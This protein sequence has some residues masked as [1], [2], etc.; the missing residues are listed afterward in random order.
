MKKVRLTPSLSL[1]WAVLSC[2]FLAPLAASSA[3]ISEDNFDYSAGNTN[4]LDGGTGWAGSWNNFY[5][6]E[7]SAIV[8]PTTALTYSNTGA[9]TIG[10][11]NAVETHRV[12]GNTSNTSMIRQSSGVATGETFYLRVLIRMESGTWDN[13]DFIVA[14]ADDEEGT[15]SSS[16]SPGPNLGLRGALSGTEDF[17][18]RTNTSNYATSDVSFVAGVTYMMV[19]KFEDTNGDDQYDTASIWI[20]PEVGDASTPQ[21]VSSV[22]SSYVSTISYAGFRL[23]GS[24]EEEDIFLFDALAITDSWD[25]AL[26]VIPESGSSSSLMGV[27]I[28]ILVL[29]YRRFRKG[30]RS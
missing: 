7:L 30:V 19:A 8:T 13:D 29:S 4:G 9:N 3:V 18:A 2:L 24:L 20:N 26:S 28:I 11:G 10:G 1:T 17:M 6:N 15:R 27:G 25:S 21:A 12:D 23:G 22:D 14:F 16:H 5:Q